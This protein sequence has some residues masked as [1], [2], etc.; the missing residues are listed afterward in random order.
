MGAPVKDPAEAAA[1]V[2]D[3]VDALAEAVFEGPNLCAV[4]VPPA[5]NPLEA[6]LLELLI[7]DRI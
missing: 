2:L 4:A 1:K 7:P 6:V 3:E 5:T